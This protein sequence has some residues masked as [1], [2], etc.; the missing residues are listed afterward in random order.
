M[1][2][3]NLEARRPTMIAAPPPD[4]KVRAYCRRQDVEADDFF[5]TSKAGRKRAHAACVQCP[6]I[7]ECLQVTRSHDEGVYRWGIGGGLD[8]SQ[9][10]AL[11]LEEQLGGS[12]NWEMA[13]VLVSSRWL[14]RLTRLRSSCGSLEGMTRALHRHGLLVDE[15]T[16]RVAVWWSGGDA[17]RVA[18]RGD[19]RAMRVR[20]AGDYLDVMLRLRAKGARYVD[21]AA[22][23]GVS[24]ESGSRAVKDV[25]RA[26]ERA[27]EA[28]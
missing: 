17:P 22:Y 14:D 10:R 9:R 20:L 15:V 11:E 5:T 25:L 12:P 13:K 16:V 26:A 3:L 7:T 23:L 21:I 18:W 28:S 2:I 4:W 19:T 24:G 6:V 8:A 27:G 1:T